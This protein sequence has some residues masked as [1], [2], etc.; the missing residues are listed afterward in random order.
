VENRR[1]A[2]TRLDELAEAIKE[3]KE[4]QEQQDALNKQILEQLQKQNESADE[5]NKKLDALIDA[6]NTANGLLRVIKWLAMVGAALGTIWVA[7]HRGKII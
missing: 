2:D 4:R 6:W 5:R 1:I 7:L 3:L